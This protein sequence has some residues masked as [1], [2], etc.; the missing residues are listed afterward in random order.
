MHAS[1]HL[2]QRAIYALP[3]TAYCFTARPMS[4]HT[5]TLTSRPYQDSQIA[6]GIT[7]MYLLGEQP[8]YADQLIN[9]LQSI[10]AQLLQGL[11]PEGPALT[12]AGSDDLCA[13][14]PLNQ[15]YRVG[16]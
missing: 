13:E 14:L 8:V 6:Q 16:R 4:S 5:A 12:F 1:S 2:E 10:P 7:V 11:S 9:R 15:L 3:G